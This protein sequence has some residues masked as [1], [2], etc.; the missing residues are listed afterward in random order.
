MADERDRKRRTLTFSLFIKT[1]AL[2]I[3]SHENI[4]LNSLKV[5][6]DRRT[7]RQ[8][9]RQTNSPKHEDHII[10]HFIISQVNV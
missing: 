8:T 6:N 3:Q 9:D 2:V 1:Y 10:S 7:D 4:Q 5:R